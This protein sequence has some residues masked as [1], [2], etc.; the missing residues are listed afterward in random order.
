MIKVRRK[1]CSS[2]CPQTLIRRTGS[3][4]FEAFRA[5]RSLR[6][7]NK[8]RQ[9]MFEDREP[10]YY[11]TAYK[12]QQDVMHNSYDLFV[13]KK[14]MK[15]FT[16]L[17]S[18][19]LLS[20]MMHKDIVLRN[21]ASSFDD[22]EYIDC[23]WIPACL[24]AVDTL[25]RAVTHGKPPVSSFSSPT[26]SPQSLL[27]ITSGMQQSGSAA[28][29]WQQLTHLDVTFDERP[30]RSYLDTAETRLKGH[31]SPLSA[32]FK[33]FCLYSEN[34]ST[35]Y[36]RFTPG[37]PVRLPLEDVFHETVWRKLRVLG[38]GSWMLRAEEIIN[39]AQRHRDTLKGLRLSEIHLMDGGRWKDVAVAL[40]AQ[41]KKLEWVGLQDI[42]YERGYVRRGAYI[43]TYSDTSSEEDYEEGVEF[44]GMSVGSNSHIH[45]SQAD[46]DVIYGNV[47]T[48]SEDT[49]SSSG[50]SS[51]GNAANA[52]FGSLRTLDETDSE[53]DLEDYGIT[54]SPSQRRHWERWIIG[55]N[56]N[57]GEAY[58]RSL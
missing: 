20:V 14:A 27:Q 19:Q 40:K 43:E 50:L 31:I 46:D 5:D 25:L 7:S 28:M 36:L 38:I 24:H 52:S 39:I 30:D 58:I 57:T 54:V 21:L 51:S 15:A 48:S 53:E 44:D 35:L 16:A 56:V 33:L 29:N 37:L 22:W 9:I 12:E 26:L 8:L 18:I 3:Q 11:P 4:D 41:M 6:F 34:L 45:P 17:Q 55:K 47:F 32:F 42:G 23:R 49:G 10:F 13:L 1:L 2:A